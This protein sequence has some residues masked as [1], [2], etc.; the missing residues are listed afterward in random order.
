MTSCTYP[1]PASPPAPVP[2]PRA[3]SRRARVTGVDLARGL[4]LL[5]MMAAHVFDE[6]TDRGPTWTGLIASGRAAAL[7]AMIAG[8]SVAF[9]SGGPRILYGRARTAASAGVATRAA[10]IGTIGLLLGLA[11]SGISVILTYYAVC[12]L[13]AIPLLGLRARTLAL[14]SIALV[15][16]GPVVLV[17]TAGLDLPETGTNA[18]T[19]GTLLSDPFGL[20]VQMFITGDYPVVAYMAFICAGLAIGRMDLTSSRVAGWLVGSGMAIAVTAQ[21]VSWVLLHPLGGM[22]RLIAQG[23]F[24]SDRAEATLALLWT[25]EVTSWWYLAL[26]APH[27]ES[28][29]DMLH[30]LGSAMAVLGAA[31]LVTRIRA[32]DRALSPVQAAGAMTLTLYSAHIL[33]LA[34][35]LFDDWET[36]QYLFLVVSCLVFAVVWRRWRPQGPLEELAGRLAGRARRAVLRG[37]GTPV[38]AGARE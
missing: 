10:V 21:A 3:T 15:A 32:V 14:L 25:P 36:A 24:G 34:V 4:A 35:G 16:A 22:D 12:F 31:L 37:S 19:L 38:G 2:P 13:L 1:V 6:V 20:L 33:V 28:T 17:A 5:G 26:P 7:F 8:V 30:V 23:N 27:S 29:I 9:L 18:P 11:D